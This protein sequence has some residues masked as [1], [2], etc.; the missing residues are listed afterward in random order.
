MIFSS[1]DIVYNRENIITACHPIAY[2]VSYLERDINMIKSGMDLY[3]M[4]T[5]Y[6][7]RMLISSSKNITLVEGMSVA[8]MNLD[9]F[10]HPFHQNFD[11]V[12]NNSDK[13]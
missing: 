8:F 7:Q 11:F 9:L 2:N 13:I 6:C 12:I 1:A 10:M 3:T 4:E 5:H